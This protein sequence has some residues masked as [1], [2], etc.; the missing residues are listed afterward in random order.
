MTESGYSIDEIDLKV[1]RILRSAFFE[2]DPFVKAMLPLHRF[3]HAV[4]AKYQFEF[5]SAFDNTIIYQGA[6]IAAGPINYLVPA[7]RAAKACELFWNGVVGGGATLDRVYLFDSHIAYQHSL[8][9]QGVWNLAAA[10]NLVAALSG[11]LLSETEMV[12]MA[13]MLKVFDSEFVDLL[14]ARH[15]LAHDE[16]RALGLFQIDRKKV[17]KSTVQ[18]CWQQGSTFGGLT[19]K[20][21]VGGETSYFDFSFSSSKILNLVTML[22][23]ICPAHGTKD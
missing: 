4:G 2:M 3:F 13:S 8:G 11:H 23:S 10:R 7:Y 9:L 18:K 14:D 15:A 6:T 12:F 17:L 20:S 22:S 21:K 1:G 19:K 5:A 16:E